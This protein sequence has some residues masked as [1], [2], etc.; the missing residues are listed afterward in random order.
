MSMLDELKKVGLTN[1]KKAKQVERAKKQQQHHDLKTGE[2]KKQMAGKDTVATNVATE[3]VPSLEAKDQEQ[4]ARLYKDAALSNFSGR[5][6]FYFTTPDCYI[7]CMCV[8]D[9]ASILLE[10]GKIAIVANSSKDDYILVKRATALAI[11]A[12]DKTRVVVLHR[13]EV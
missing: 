6:K 9:V 1:D 7:D 13:Q 5:K 12:I 2:A 3:A 11:E 4:L 8:S 10:R